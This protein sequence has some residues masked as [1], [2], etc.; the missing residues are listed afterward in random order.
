MNSFE[1]P[2]NS[3][4][5]TEER[6]N[7]AIKSTQD[8]LNWL[9]SLMLIAWKIS[10]KQVS[11]TTLHTNEEIKELLNKMKKWEKVW[12]IIEKWN[13]NYV[14]QI[15]EDLGFKVSF[16]KNSKIVVLEKEASWENQTTF[17]KKDIN[18]KQIKEREIV[19]EKHK[20]TRNLVL[21]TN[22]LLSVLEKRQTTKELFEK[23]EKIEVISKDLEWNDKKQIQTTIKSLEALKVLYKTVDIE[24]I[25]N[26]IIKN[27]S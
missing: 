19:S 20:M 27:I 13:K 17:I 2:I 21:F 9:F 5:K 11:K 18:K 3:P 16:K 6:T 1:K 23:L 14:K 10:W 25:I 4:N 26:N 8:K 15:I 22:T 12:I 7:L 24:P